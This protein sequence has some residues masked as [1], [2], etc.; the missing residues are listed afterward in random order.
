VSTFHEWFTGRFWREWVVA[1]RN[2][3]TEVRSKEYI[4]QRHLKPAFGDVKLDEI[5]TSDVAAFRAS[6]VEKGS[7]T[8][9]STTS[10]WCCRSR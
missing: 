7:A 1:R 8:S 10:S 4:Y 9:G 3:P 2:K 5:G 6:L